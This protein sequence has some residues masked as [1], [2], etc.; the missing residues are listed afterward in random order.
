MSETVTVGL[1]SPPNSR[2][3]KTASTE[4][5]RI[6]LS[7][8]RISGKCECPVASADRAGI[9]R[10]VHAFRVF[11]WYNIFHRHAEYIVLH[12]PEMPPAPLSPLLLGWQFCQAMRRQLQAYLKQ[13][14]SNVVSV[15]KTSS[16]RK[17]YEFSLCNPKN[18]A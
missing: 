3:S 13:K 9:L 12:T 11:G 15:L 4:H 17:H 1:E 5:Y 7:T 10:K 18:Y 2:L 6:R 8:S 14:L 16:F